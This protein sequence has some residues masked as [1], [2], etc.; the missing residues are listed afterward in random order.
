MSTKNC[1]ILLLKIL[2]W[3]EKK[4]E[5]SDRDFNNELNSLRWKIKRYIKGE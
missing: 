3:I 1:R 5:G 4:S 2:D